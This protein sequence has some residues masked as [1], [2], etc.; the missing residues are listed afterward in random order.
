[1]GKTLRSTIA[2]GGGRIP[3]LTPPPFLTPLWSAGGSRKSHLLAH[4][5]NIVTYDH[6]VIYTPHWKPQG[7]AF[8]PESRFSTIFSIKLG[9]RKTLLS[10]SKKLTQRVSAKL[11]VCYRKIGQT[12][13]S[14]SPEQCTSPVLM[15][16]DP[17]TIVR[18]ND[19]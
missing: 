13:M 3:T 4:V 16:H 19:T 14:S 2:A 9:Q 12:A 8:H 18:P 15:A 5:I 10:F 11:F 7:R 1:M 17:N 6:R